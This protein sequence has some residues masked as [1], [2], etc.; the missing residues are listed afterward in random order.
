[1][2][3]VLTEELLARAERVYLMALA[4]EAGLYHG[5]DGVSAGFERGWSAEE[6][7]NWLT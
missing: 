6:K 3:G 2:T 4:R 5:R 1:M 7:K